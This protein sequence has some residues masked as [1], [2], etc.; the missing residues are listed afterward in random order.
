[1]ANLVFSTFGFIMNLIKRKG[2]IMK[3]KKIIL[4]IIIVIFGNSL[5]WFSPT[6]ISGT[7][8]L[9]KTTNKTISIGVVNWLMFYATLSGGVCT[10]LAIVLSYWLN[11]KQLKEQHKESIRTTLHLDEMNNIS[12]VNKSLSDLIQAFNSNDQL[13]IVYNFI[14]EKNYLDSYSII[15]KV[16]NNIILYSNNFYLISDI[17]EVKENIDCS[18]CNLNKLGTCK[19]YD[20]VKKDL[21]KTIENI[22][23]CYMHTL[24]KIQNYVDALSK[25]E[26]LQNIIIECH[27][28]ISEALNLNLEI[29]VDS[30][31]PK[32]IENNK[33]IDNS[34]KTIE[35]AKKSII[36]Q[37]KIDEYSSE[38][39]KAME[40]YN[41]KTIKEMAK[42]LELSKKYLELKKIISIQKLNSK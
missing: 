26:K 38:L 29:S 41:E 35:D 2:E 7:I 20:K 14:K 3:I 19:E 32:Y 28:I 37:E 24:E 34:K 36:S 1:M 33:V 42:L 8:E 12:E 21:D 4:I 16:R 13:R 17:K 25:N 9:M 30:N 31:S 6:I 22:Y 23:N 40:E 10:L 39:D 5:L 11:N 18:K 15:E 27:R